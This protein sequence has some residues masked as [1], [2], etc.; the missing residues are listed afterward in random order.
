LPNA[1]NSSTDECTRSDR[2]TLPVSLNRRKSRLRVPRRCGVSAAALLYLS[3]ALSP[4]LTLVWPARIAR[5]QDFSG[6]AAQLS[7]GAFALL[8]SLSSSDGSSSPALGAV[9]SFAGDAQTLSSALGADKQADAGAAMA[10]LVADRSAVDAAL[11]A[12]PGAVNTAEWNSLKQQLD[13]LAAQVKPVPPAAAAAAP[14]AASTPAGEAE[15]S[16]V[17]KVRID[18]YTVSGHTVRI[19]GIFEG[20]A[21]KSAGVYNGDQ[22]AQDLKIDQLPGRQQ[23][24]FDVELAEV[25]PDSVL[26]VYDGAGLSAEASIASRLGMQGTGLAKD[27]ELG[28][29]SDEPVSLGGDLASVETDSS[30]H[31][32]AEVP[33]EVPPSSPSQRHVAG[34]GPHNRLGDFQVNIVSATL[35][36]PETR[37]YDVIGQINGSGMN[38][39]GIYVDGAL[40]QS[41]DLDS[42]N[43]FTAQPFDEDF[44]MTGH[45]ATLRVYNS[46][47]EYLEAPIVLAAATPEFPND[48]PAGM[49]PIMV[50]ANPNPNQL[51]VQITSM[52][53]QA[54]NL[55]L[56][57]GVLSG[58]NMSAA[59][60][61]QN[62][63]QVQPLSVAPGLLSALSA[64]S[65]RQVNFTAQVNPIVGPASIRLFDSTGQFIEQPVMV[66][67]V[68]PY[69]INRYGMNPYAPAV[70]PYAPGVS[71]YGSAVNPYAPPYGN[72]YAYPPGAVPP[73]ASSNP[74]WWSRLLH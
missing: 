9:A 39:A 55:T 20:V 35:D 54:A 48:M 3:F 56:I 15:A 69:A 59:G 28:P 66:A 72:P 64:G 40:S 19:R 34:R 23:V 5:A 21:L 4:L 42:D 44:R 2:S 17:P 47:N 31:N 70:N 22:L 27:V 57:G 52:T 53:Q 29:P 51:A 46:G 71:P 6:A 13:Q 63:V 68:N 36:D 18:S 58:K 50:N 41:I 60:I 12:H 74:P 26:R 7:D 61:Y 38:H 11:S 33:A 65:F 24:S 62:G 14:G 45:K 43:A 10:A 37:T 1:T 25:E 67:G 8:N 30:G 16:D 73:P 32:V 49:P